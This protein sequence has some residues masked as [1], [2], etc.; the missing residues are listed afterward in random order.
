M[1]FF[2]GDPRTRAITEG[3][4]GLVGRDVNVAMGEEPKRDFGEW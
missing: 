2:S 4:T 1:L 3:K